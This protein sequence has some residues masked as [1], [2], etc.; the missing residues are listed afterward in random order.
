MEQQR[1]EVPNDVRPV[2]GAAEK[3][4]VFLIDTSG[5]M[6]WPIAEGSKVVRASL[7]GEAMG[8]IIAKLESLDSQAT[9]EQAGGSHEKGGALTFLF[10]DSATELGDL[11]TENWKDKWRTINWGGGTAI[12]PAYELAVND[13]I[14]EFGTTSPM[15]RPAHILVVFTDGEASDATAFAQVLK[16]TQTTKTPRYVVVCTLGY[17]PEHDK[18]VA[19]YQ[20][21]AASNPHCRVLLFGGDT[22]PTTISNDVLQTI[23]TP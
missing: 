14:E 15:D 5:S 21:I 6:T 2:A 10:S 7:L 8:T 9:A 12:M 19:Q 22:D 18:I 17:G 4:L 20:A 11:N 16:D 13:Y 1:T 3:E 23:G